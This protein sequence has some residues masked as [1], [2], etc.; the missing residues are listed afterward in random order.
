MSFLCKNCKKEVSTDGNIGTENRN[1]CPYCMYSIHLDLNTPGDR[2]SKCEGLMVP[3][4]LTYKEEGNDKYGKK[5]QGEIMIVHKC[6][7]CSKLS[8]NRL[9][10]DDDP[11]VVMDI[12]E[13]SLKQSHITDTNI[14]LLREKDREGIDRQ[15]NGN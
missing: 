7:N 13:N 5:R 12:F 8:I 15:L 9:A 3:I 2:E 11:K 10:A 4:G 6:S 1:H 14:T